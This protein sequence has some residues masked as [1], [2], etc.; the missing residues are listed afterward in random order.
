[1]AEQHGAETGPSVASEG[2]AVWQEENSAEFIDHGRVLTPGRDEIG[3]TLLDLVPAAPDEA[4]VAVEM[5]S[6]Q[7]WLSEALLRR[8]P[9]ARVIALD[10]SAAMLRAAGGLL[11]PFGDRVELRPFRLEDPA[12]PG[13]LGTEVRCFLSSLVVH[14]LDESGKRALFARLRDR[15]EPGGALLLADIVAPTSERGRR[16]MARAWE[17]EVRRRSLAFDGDLRAYDFFVE[18]G[19]NTFDHP[20]D[21]LDQPSPLPDQLRWLAEVGFVGV[22]VFWARAGH[23]VY[24]GYKPGRTPST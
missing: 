14:H 18:S 19:W 5:G 11:A 7:G 3:R 6:G 15:L 16:H 23:A 24:G 12:W 9:R 20:D 1:M 8:F 10:G 2:E 17:D 13:R 21:P 4:F 22:D